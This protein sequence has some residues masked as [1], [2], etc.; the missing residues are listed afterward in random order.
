MSK[1]ENRSVA[2]V[3]LVAWSVV[4]LVLIAMFVA[5]IVLRIGNVMHF[6]TGFY[7]MSGSFYEDADTYNVGNISYTDDIKHIDVDWSAGKID[8]VIWDG[9]GV[10][11]EESG[12]GD[13]DRNKMRSRVDGD[14]LQIK[15]IKSG[16]AWFA[17]QPEKS[18]VI[19]VPADMALS[20]GEVDIA[21]ASADVTVG[22]METDGTVVIACRPS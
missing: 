18:L 20:L 15:F 3:K 12:H 9:D 2:I 4:A 1:N 17:S 19:Y 14:T 5:M 11:L 6:E 13:V 16:H 21:A 10:K 7:I 8:V 22:D